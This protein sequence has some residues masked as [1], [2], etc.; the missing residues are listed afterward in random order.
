MDRWLMT[1]HLRA[2]LYVFAVVGSLIAVWLGGGL[3]G[4]LIIL[5]FICAF[6]GAGGKLPNLMGAIAKLSKIFSQ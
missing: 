2:G 4:S 3:V 5:A 6:A 1:E